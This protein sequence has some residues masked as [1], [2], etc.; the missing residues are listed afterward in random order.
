MLKRLTVLVLC[1]RVTVSCG[2]DGSGQDIGSD[3]AGD[4]ASE[5]ADSQTGTDTDATDTD[6]ADTSVSLDVT[7]TASPSDDADADDAAADVELDIGRDTADTGEPQ[8]TSPLD[9]VDTTDP[10]DTSEPSDTTPAEDVAPDTIPADTAPDTTPNRSP[11]LSFAIVPAG[12]ILPGQSVTLTATGSDPD[13]DAL[14]FSLSQLTLP[15]SGTFALLDDRSATWIA[16]ELAVTSTFEFEAEVSDGINERVKVAVEVQVRIPLFATDIAPIFTANCTGCHGASG[17]LSLSAGAAYTN[18]VN[19]AGNNAACN[20]L[21]RVLPGAPNDSLLVRK[22][23]GA[24]CGSRMPRSDP[25]FFVNN[26]GLITRIR[27]WIL[28]GAQNN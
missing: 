2:D 3:D 21:K 6:R 19:V 26:S 24:D 18:L 7:D 11:T 13:G 28:A 25:D 15:P 4:I 12:P 16:P 22:I 8:D 20:T 23:S 1:A 14:T 5:V 9:V 10:G 17:G 27:S